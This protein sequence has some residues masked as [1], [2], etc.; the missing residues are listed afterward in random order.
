[1]THDTTQDDARARFRNAM[2]CL[3]AAVNVI[4]TDGPRGRNGI[5]ASAV[6]SVTDSPPTMLVCINQS[7]YVHDVLHDNANVCIN[8][9]GAH[10]QALAQLFAGMTGCSMDARFDQCA[11]TPGHAGV[12]VLDDAMSSLQGRIVDSKTVGSH[13]VIFVEIER[14]TSRDEGDG[15]VYFGRQFH[16]LPRAAACS[17]AA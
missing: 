7:S 6:C 9:L 4:T 10:S 11:W 13:S 15:L 12:P 2:A 1:M 5:T 17:E 3:G 14:I 16:R 8:V